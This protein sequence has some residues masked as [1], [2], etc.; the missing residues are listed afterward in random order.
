[1]AVV[2]PAAATPSSTTRQQIFGTVGIEQVLRE[3]NV[4]LGDTVS[5]QVLDAKD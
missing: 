4:N 2:Q 1:L 3:V 5:E